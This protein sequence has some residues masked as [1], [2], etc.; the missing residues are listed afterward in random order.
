MLCEKSLMKRNT[1]TPNSKDFRFPP[2]IISHAVWRSFRFSLSF[3]E[4]EDLSAQRGIVRSSETV[5][6]WCLKFGQTW[7]WPDPVKCRN[8]TVCSSKGRNFF[9]QVPLQQRSSRDPLSFAPLNR[10]KSTPTEEKNQGCIFP[11]SF[12]SFRAGGSET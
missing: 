1:I 6:Q 5:R 10:V 8:R 2:E 4:V 12:L 3:R 9:N 11:G 7:S